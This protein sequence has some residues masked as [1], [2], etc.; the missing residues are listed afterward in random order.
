MECI[1][2]LRKDCLILYDIWDFAIEIVTNYL[3]F[4]IKYDY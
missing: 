3:N 2:M 1:T 4:Y